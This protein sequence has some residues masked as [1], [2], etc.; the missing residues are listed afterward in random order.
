LFA[1]KDL[2]EAIGFFSLEASPSPWWPA[3]ESRA[4]YLAGMVVARSARNRGIGSFII[5]WS[6][7]Q[8]ARLGFQFVRLDCHAE[9]LWLC[10]YYEAH[11]F[12][13]RGKVEQHP[14]YFGFLYQQE[15]ESAFQYS[16]ADENEI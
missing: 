2:D 5:D 1:V 6:V 8:A 14:G 15:V 11:G 9:N 3:D 4:L 10:R 13:Y 16:N 7:N 12:T